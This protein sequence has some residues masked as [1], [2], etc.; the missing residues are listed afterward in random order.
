M[1]VLSRKQGQSIQ[2]SPG[3][4]ITV[5]QISGSRVVLGF[6]APGDIRIV[7]EELRTGA[8]TAMRT[9]PTCNRRVNIAAPVGRIA[10][11]GVEV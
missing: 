8:P 10:H 6:E 9:Q 3:V 5:Q 7:R 1:L 4:K 11:R 2:I